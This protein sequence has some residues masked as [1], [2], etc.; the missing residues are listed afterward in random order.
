MTPDELTQS[1]GARIRAIRERRNLTQDRLAHAS[2][3][4]RTAIGKLERGERCPSITTLYRVTT[5]LEVPLSEL[6]LGIK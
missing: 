1:I 6:F 2:G 4:D 5:A 3:L